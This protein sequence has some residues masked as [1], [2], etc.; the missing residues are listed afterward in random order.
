MSVVRKWV[1]L[2]TKEA[3]MQTAIVILLVVLALGFLAWK[4]KKSKGG[5]C[6]SGKCGCGH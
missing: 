6:G 5:G 2:S 3:V 1:F 4:I